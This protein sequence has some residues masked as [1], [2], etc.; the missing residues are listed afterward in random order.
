MHD[1]DACL[2]EYLRRWIWMPSISAHPI[3]TDAPPPRAPGHTP[4]HPCL[5]HAR[6]RTCTHG[7]RIRPACVRARVRGR[8]RKKYL[9]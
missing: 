3:N 4:M 8:G 5:R 6:A 7:A 9:T 2:G 1:P